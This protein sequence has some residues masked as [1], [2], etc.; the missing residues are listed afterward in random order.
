MGFAK[1]GPDEVFK[2]KRQVL[3]KC[4]QKLADTPQCDD[5]ADGSPW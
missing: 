2:A 5:V 1:K 3:D 4:G